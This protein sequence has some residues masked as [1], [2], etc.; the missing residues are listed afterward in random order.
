LTLDGPAISLRGLRKAYG[1]KVVLDGIDLE[2]RRGEILGYIGPNGAGKSTTIKVLIGLLPEFEGEVRVAG[3]DPRREPL[4]VKRRIG[5]VAENATLFEPLTVAEFLLFVGRMHGLDDATIERRATAS[6]A[7]FEIEGRVSSRIAELSKGMRQKVL[8][9]AAWIHAPP[10]LMLDEPMSGL[11]V[12]SQLLVKDVIRR[13]AARGT[14]VVLSSH[15]MD[16]VERLCER[17][18]IVDGG[19]IVAQGTFEELARTRRG[20]SLEGIFA[21]VT[22]GGDLEARAGS[23]VGALA[24]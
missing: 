20:G 1:P 16:V 17:I 10:V 12:L 6:L 22:G 11:D 19:R 15:V 4:E 18:A 21:T 7:A 13:L 24:S 23:L 8:L 14:T 5:Y 9:T 3:F 2:V